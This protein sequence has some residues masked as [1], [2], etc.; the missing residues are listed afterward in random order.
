M[1]MALVIVALLLY[2]IHVTKKPSEGLKYQKNLLPL[3]IIVLTATMIQ[4]ILGTQVRQFV[5]EQ[6]DQVGETA[7][8]LWLADV[9]WTFYVHRSFSIA[10]VLLN[11][12]LAYRIRKYKLGFSK[13]NAVLLLLTAEVITGVAMFYLDFPF[14]SQP[15]HLIIA[16]L[17]FGV[18]FYLVLEFFVTL[19]SHKNEHHDL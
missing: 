19:P 11:L 2:I 3:L 15:I 14:A 10:V 4:I 16:S 8:S 7:K 13:I 5:D 1:V 17:L 6:I 18:Q 9:D 12:L